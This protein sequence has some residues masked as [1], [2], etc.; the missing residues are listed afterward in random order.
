MVYTMV[1][2]AVKNA[3]LL[4]AITILL[5]HCYYAYCRHDQ[6]EWF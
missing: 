2:D 3:L 4:T 1:E 5:V 6:G